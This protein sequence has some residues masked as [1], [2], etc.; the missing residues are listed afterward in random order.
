MY[1]TVL[2]EFARLP[3][4]GRWPPRSQVWWSVGH[5]PSLTPVANICSIIT[6]RGA[7]YLTDAYSKYIQYNNMAGASSHTD[8][9]SKLMQYNNMA[10]ASS[11]T[12]ACSKHIQYNNMAGAS[13]LTDSCSKHIQYNNWIFPIKIWFQRNLRQSVSTVMQKYV[14]KHHYFLGYRKNVPHMRELM[15]SRHQ[16]QRPLICKRL[17]KLIS[18]ENYKKTE[19]CARN[20][21]MTFTINN[22]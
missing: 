21:L 14:I 22:N 12:D 15:A 3:S 6:W 2:C 13:S 18:A 5:P 7:S 20:V 11:H 1:H 9:C 10:G 8:A 19:G 4:P 16:G 17:L